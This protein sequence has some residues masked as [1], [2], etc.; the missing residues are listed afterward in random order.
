MRHLENISCA[1]FAPTRK[2][3][4]KV[5]K[6]VLLLLRPH[7]LLRLSLSAFFWAWPVSAVRTRVRACCMERGRRKPPPLVFTPFPCAQ[8]K[9]FVAATHLGGEGGEQKAKEAHPP[10]RVIAAT[11]L[12]PK[13][14][15]R[16]RR[17]NRGG[18]RRRHTHTYGKRGG[19]GKSHKHLTRG[20]GGSEAAAF[21]KV[22]SPSPP[23]ARERE[24]KS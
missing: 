7:F 14:E 4:K 12:R 13:P 9:A 10:T 2:K 3:E 19:G 20:R 24:R 16:R 17:R 11:L 21:K 1:F 15:W 8:K 18:R 5:R 6:S 23:R 22:W